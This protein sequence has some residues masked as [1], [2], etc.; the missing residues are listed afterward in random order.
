MPTNASP[1][2]AVKPELAQLTGKWERPDGGYVIEIKGV[3]SA[4]TMEAAYYN[5]SPIHVARAAALLKEGVPQVFIE[6][7]DQ[8][9]PGCTYS[10]TY[11]P[12][13][14]QLYGQYFQ[15]AIQETYNVTF[16]RLK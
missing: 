13:S 15:A 6:L 9:Y 8:N 2:A 14:D 7:R 11:D 1:V 4:G 3:D 16:A 10:L 5:P 12:K